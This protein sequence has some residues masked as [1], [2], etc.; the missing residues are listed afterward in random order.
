MAHASKWHIQAWPALAVP[1]VRLSLVLRV[2]IPLIVAVIAFSTLLLWAVEDVTEQRL[3]EDVQL[4]ARAIRLPVSYSLEKG[5]SGSVEQA[6]ESAFQIGRVYGAYV[7][8]RQGELLA[9]V[10]AEPDEPRLSIDERYADGAGSGTYEQIEG[11]RVYSYFVPLMEASGQINGL[12]QVTRRRS[13]FAADIQQLRRQ[14]LL[15][16]VVLSLLI[17][18]LVLW[19]HR[20]AIGRHLKRLADS[21]ARIERGDRSHRSR[22]AGPREIAGLGRAFNGMLDSMARAQQQLI[23]GRNAQAQL[24]KRL[25]QNEKMAAIGRLSAGV[26]HELGTPLN[27]IDGLAQRSLRAPGLDAR[28]AQ[29]LEEI[30]REVQRVSAVVRQLLDVGRVAVPAPAQTRV[31][32]LIGAAAASAEDTL[33][34]HGARLQ[35]VAPDD[36][37]QIT[38]DAVRIQQA[39]GNLLRNAAQAGARQIRLS[40]T[41]TEDDII[42]RVDDDGP[43]IPADIANSLFE[44]F[45]TTKPVGKGSGL[46]LAIVHGVASEHGGTIEIETSRLGGACFKLSIPR[47]GHMAEWR[48][49]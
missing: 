36:D 16:T 14:A 29:Q 13:D 39:L 24:E 5:R 31:S 15:L 7:Y 49:P 26:A 9:A 37:P 21:M 30:R 27:V 40:W 4:V 17:T 28:L 41:A 6:L 33:N 32:T 44:P 12:L 45:F 47:H 46:G 3:K 8:D 1:S 10:G 48:Q 18:I 23:D 2:V 25:R 38:A 43:G 42:F 34:R 22:I 20:D 19:G 35:I 11:R